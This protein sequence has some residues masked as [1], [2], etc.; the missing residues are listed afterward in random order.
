MYK[1]MV[2]AGPNRGSSFPIHS[3]ENWIGR[4]AGNAVVLIS[5]KISKR[6][7][8]VTVRDSE[9][10]V[11]DPGSANGTFVN[12]A[13]SRS[14]K[15]K[16]GDRIS[17]GEFV[18]QLMEA[19]PQRTAP[20]AVVLD[21]PRRDRG[22]AQFPVSQGGGHRSRGANA[23][24]LNP[25]ASAD[26]ARYHQAQAAAA[27]QVKAQAE[28]LRVPTDLKGKLLYYIDQ[29][30][31]P[32]FFG[33]N[34]KHEWKAICGW[35]F[36]IFVLGN[37][38]ISV[39]PLLESSR[40]TIVKEVVKR[41]RYMARQIADQ[42]SQYLAARAETKTEIGAAEHADGVRVAVLVDLSNRIIA[43]ALKQNS[44]LAN[45][46][47][48]MYAV[49]AAEA[50][51]KGQER[52]LA[53]EIDSETIAAYEPVKVLSSSKGRN[54]I[55]GMAVVSIDTTQATESLGEMG[56]V[57]SE[58]LI[59][60]GIMAGILLIILYKLT[61]KPFQVLVDDM[62]KVLKGDMNQVTQEFQFEEMA[63]LWDLINSA[64]QRVPKR[65]TDMMGGGVEQADTGLTPEEAAGPV[66]AMAESAGMGVVVC[67][68]DRKVAYLNPYFEEVAGIR[69]DGAVG[70][71][72]SGLAR[73]Q[74]FSA[75]ISDLFDRATAGSDA[76]EKFEF[77]GVDYEVKAVAAGS[78]PSG[79]K[80]LVLM[81]QKVVVE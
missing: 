30:I 19:A 39:Q 45:G 14:K 44:Y 35:S 43:P 6:H 50:F 36:A 53:W 57:Y 37:L 8:V 75:L 23:L 62:D 1:L 25:Y 78:G 66:A 5:S 60:T 13:L 63:P 27:A 10:V 79:P 46:P 80:A 32:F 51:K 59:L 49:K 26:A 69:A 20:D 40:T 48:A 47:E 31:M 41:A 7:C 11:S 17:V 3:G 67:G 74:A 16:V 71:D 18:L 58:T 70:E 22:G 61:I 55:V 2:V 33:L 34:L 42:N 52:G 68:S 72:L 9:I 73:D 4:Q 54:E 24:A 28:A 12:G 21:H 77:S 81:I 15:L 65:G 38:L 64:L 56:V 76:S 29:F